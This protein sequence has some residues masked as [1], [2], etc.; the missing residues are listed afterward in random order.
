MRRAEAGLALAATLHCLSGCA[1]GEV[2]GMA[3]GAM[4]GW[5]NGMTIAVSIVLAFVFGYGLTIRSLVAGGMPLPAAAR[6]ALA[7]DSLSIAVMELVDNLFMVVVPGAMD[8]GI[9]EIRFWLALLGSLVLAGVVAFPVN[10]WLIRRGGGHALVHRTH[11]GH[12]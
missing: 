1:I 8:A 3:L 12:H 11:A 2:L 5:S 4:L 9:E 7:S 6:I 10:A